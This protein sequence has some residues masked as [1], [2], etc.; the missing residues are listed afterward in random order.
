VHPYTILHTYLPLTSCALVIRKNTPVP[1]GVRQMVA[2]RFIGSFL[3]SL[4]HRSE[5]KRQ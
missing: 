3:L 5:W 4:T 2:L 1:K